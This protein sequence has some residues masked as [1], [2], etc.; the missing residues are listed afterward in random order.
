[1]FVNPKE[2]L[3]RIGISSGLFVADFGAG[4]GHWSLALA[5]M[6]GEEGVVFAIDIQRELL[7]RLQAQAREQGINNIRIITGDL[8]EIGGSKLRDVQADVVVAA[9]ILFQIEEKGKFIDEVKRVLKSK[10]RFFLVDW[11]ESFG[12]MGPSEEAVIPKEK[13][14]TLIERAGLEFVEDVK[15]GAHHYGILFRKP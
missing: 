14:R 5:R 7:T 6:V 1:M 2:T 10:G 13:A 9:N 4:S 15:S 8:D 3:E 11:G 12:G